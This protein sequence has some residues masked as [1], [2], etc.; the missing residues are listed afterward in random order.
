MIRVIESL[1]KINLKPGDKFKNAGHNFEVIEQSGDYT[2][3]KSL[4]DT[5]YS[6]VVAYA[7]DGDYSWGQGHYFENEK[8]AI[9]YFNEHK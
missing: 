8:N 5:L 3:L 9:K 1:N 7:L 4:D 6:H 2:L